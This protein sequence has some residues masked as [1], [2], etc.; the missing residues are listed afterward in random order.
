MKQKIIESLL[1][2]KGEEGITLNQIKD[3]FQL[4]TTASAKAMINDFIKIY[5]NGERGII[6]NEFNNI[7]K[8]STIPEAKNYISDLVTKEQKSKLSTSALE[9]V[10]IIAYKAPITKSNINAI[11]G[12][13]SEHI[14]NNL[15]LKGIIEEVGI[16]KT[17]GN[18][19]LF[20]VTD[21]FY[22]YFKIRSINELPR[23]IEF[24]NM[25]L[26]SI[27]EEENEED[28]IMDL[29]ASQRED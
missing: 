6:V 18:P 25:D 17:P 28:N 29:Y 23:L 19:I 24:N 8:F 15:L 27:N 3:I 12:K 2:V 10:G 21:K 1:Y 4:D 9:V 20:G 22:D 7:Y 26:D 14:V 13:S 16:A 11:R 5:N